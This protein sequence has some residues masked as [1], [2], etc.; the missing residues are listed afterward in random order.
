MSTTQQL[1][2]QIDAALQQELQLAQELLTLLQAEQQT[3]ANNDAAQLGAIAARKQQVASALE[4]SARQRASLL[5]EGRASGLQIN[6]PA[7]SAEEQT[8]L[9]PRWKDLQNLLQK[10]R[11][12][13]QINGRVVAHT[14]AAVRQ[15]LNALH[16]EQPSGA[17]YGR[18][19][20]TLDTPVPTHTL[21]KA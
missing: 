20:S 1:V 16:G 17:L 2:E 11:N 9:R 15:A 5:P 10:C 3:L 12:L 6:W 18:S 14:R 19:G 8:R 13:N 7:F 21:A 4:G